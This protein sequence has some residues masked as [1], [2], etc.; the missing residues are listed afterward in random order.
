MGP[1]MIRMIF[2]AALAVIGFTQL[3]GMASQWMDGTKE[4][5][6][7]KRIAARAPAKAVQHTGRTRLSPDR[8]GH[9]SA[10]AHI[11]NRTIDVMIDT[12]ASTVALTHEDARRLGLHPRKSDFTR[13]VSTANG[14]VHVA[15]VTLGSVRIGQVE[16]RH[17]SAVI[18]PKGVMDKSLM[19]MSFLKKLKRVEMASGKLILEN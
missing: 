13:R 14:L 4:T 9:F 15:P 5:E 18:M 1:A 12:G 10:R 6:P 11:N 3:A 16:E 8:L 17:I 19:G 2:L 7:E